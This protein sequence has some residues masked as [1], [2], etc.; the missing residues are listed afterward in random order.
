ML[1]GKY[2]NAKRNECETWDDFQIK[3]KFRF[4]PSHLINAHSKVITPAIS[5]TYEYKS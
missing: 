2:P 5:H 4:L 1:A 3:H